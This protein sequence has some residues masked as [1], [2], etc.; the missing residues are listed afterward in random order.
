MNGD[1]FDD[2]PDDPLPARP[3]PLTITR[4]IALLEADVL[5]DKRE[6]IRLLERVLVW[7]Q[8]MEAQASDAGW[9]LETHRQQAAARRDEEIGRM[10]GGG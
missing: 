9:E 8:R 7:K 6:M 3:Q 1:L 5:I 10:G 2:K 4:A